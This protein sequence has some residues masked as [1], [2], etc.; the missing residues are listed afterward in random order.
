MHIGQSGV[1]LGKRHAVGSVSPVITSERVRRRPS[2]A[3]LHT[4][5]CCAYSDITTADA[6]AMSKLT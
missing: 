5:D 6:H 1:N 4:D 2:G 3:E